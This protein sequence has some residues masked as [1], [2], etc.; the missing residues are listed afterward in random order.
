MDDVAWYLS[1][2]GSQPHPVGQK[3]A[4]DFKLYDM[5]GN[6]REWVNDWFDEKYYL[7]SLLL[8]PAG[9]PAGTERVARGGSWL[10]HAT[11]VRVSFRFKGEPA[12]KY[13]NFGFRCVWEIAAP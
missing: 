11:S 7:R 2:S 6:L 9:P 13:A 1:N 12:G 4:N 8:D 3:R 5:L 10:D